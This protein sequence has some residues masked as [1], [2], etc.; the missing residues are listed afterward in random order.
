[1]RRA[2]AVRLA[3]LLA[4]LLVAAAGCGGLATGPR[5]PTPTA[6]PA[7]VPTATASYPPGVA[8]DGVE[9]PLA[10]ANA[11]AA[12]VTG[13]SAFRSRWT[14]RGE[15]GSLRERVVLS[16]R[17]TPDAWRSSITVAGTDPTILSHSAARGVFYSDGRELVGRRVAGGETSYQYESP[18]RYTGGGFFGRLQHPYP[19]VPLDRLLG[20]VDLRVVEQRAGGVVL[21]GDALADRG[22][23]AA[24][25]P[26]REPANVSVRLFVDTRGVI[27]FQRLSYEATYRDERVTVVREVRYVAVG[28]VSVERPTWYDEA[29]ENGGL[30]PS[31]RR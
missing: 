22:H 4:G 16:G 31:W 2:T 25:V 29:V 26:G 19:H 12:A 11:H 13:S 1:M 6:S 21:A 17:V 8:A 28:N 7:P 24:A 30:Y 27:R 10:V 15:D 18:A 5:E 9:R 20:S 23:F 14:V 3:P